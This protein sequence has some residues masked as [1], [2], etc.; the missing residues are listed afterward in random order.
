MSNVFIAFQ[1]NEESRAIVNA[2]LADNPAAIVNDQPA[3][4]KIDVP[5]RMVIR[6]STIEEE[7]G[8]DFDLQEM[9]IHLITMSGNVDETDEE[10]TLCWN[11]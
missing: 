4:V 5:G 8:R 10:F 6:K 11:Q 3:M 2:I 9:Q 7:I 1:K